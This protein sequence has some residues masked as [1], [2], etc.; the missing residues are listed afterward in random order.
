MNPDY[1]K[2]PKIYQ[3]LSK[4]GTKYPDLLVAS[5]GRILQRAES[6]WGSKEGALYFESLILEDRDDRNGF[7]PEVLSDI[8]LIKQVHESLFPGFTISIHDPFNNIEIAD[9][10]G[11]QVFNSAAEMDAGIAYEPVSNARELPAADPKPV[12][13]PIPDVPKMHTEPAPTVAPNATP[14]SV[15]A[16][17]NATPPSDKKFVPWPNIRTLH[18]L[19]EA[20]EVRRN[21]GQIYAAQGK[22]IGEILKSVGLIDDKVLDGVEKRHQTKKAKDKPTGELLVYMGIIEQESLTR[23][24]C[25]QSGVLMVVVHAINVPFEV[26]KR[27]PNEKAGEKRAM[28]VGINK[29][30][31]FLAVNDPFNFSDQQYFAF[32][33]GLNI[34]LV[35]APL[36]EIIERIGTKWIEPDS[37]IWTG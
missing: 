26:L 18:E 16:K 34:K 31:L 21:G 3:A 8:W 19:Y 36:D 37:E 7:P 29:G 35:F 17:K 9:T 5:F 25:I 12:A 30:T 4:V 27:V 15:Q 22:K 10:S 13:A 1:E 2:Y 20:D 11:I 32:T 23:A 6:L 14:D 28:P 24:L 33:T